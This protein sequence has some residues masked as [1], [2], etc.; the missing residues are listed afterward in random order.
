MGQN[1]VQMLHKV[2]IICLLNFVLSN[3]YFIYNDTIY[4]QIHGCAMGSPVSPVV[5]NLCMEEIEETAINSTPVPPKIWKRYVDDSFCVIK[6]NA[7]ASFHDSLNSIDPHIS[8]TIEHESNGQLSFLDTLIS[9]DNNKL[10]I[11]VY[12]KPTHT[13]RYLDFN[14]HHDREHKISTAATLLHRALKLPNSESGKAHEIDRISIAL[15]SNG[16]PPKVTADIIRKKSSNPP[17]PSPEELVG[18]F[19]SWADPMNSQSFAVLPYIKGITEPLTR[20]LKSHDIRVTNK[21][22]KT[23]QQEFPV[24]KFRPRVDDQCNVVYKIPCASCPWSYIGETKR[25]F[26]TRRKEH[27][28]NTKQCAKG[29]NV[30][31]HAWT[32]DHAID[33]ENAEIIDKGNNRIRKTLESWHTAKTVEADNNS[34]PL[35]GQ[36]NILLNKQ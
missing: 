17:T 4:K 5:A 34:C 35:P 9:R 3:N 19:F 30:A 8:F 27:I 28:R 36:Y 20:I 11:D 1:V 33:F 22:I 26:S 14:S 25:S 23:L 16:Y 13:D 21:P 29:S 2:Y 31:K 18:M 6:K 12:R 24:P 15:Q 7:V 10:N 32:L